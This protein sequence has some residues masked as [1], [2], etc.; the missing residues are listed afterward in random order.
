MRR[1]MTLAVS[2]VFCLA[3]GVAANAAK[4]PA[5]AVVEALHDTLLAV[6]KDAEALGFGGRRDRLA[7]VIAGSFDMALIARVST[8]RHWKKFD[9]AQRA[10]F[11]E[12]IGRLSVAIYAARFDDYSGESFRVVSEQPAPRGTVFVNS[13]L[14]KSDGEAVRLNYLLR[15]TDSDWRIVDVYLEGKYSELAVRRSEYLAVIK[16]KGVDG[17]LAAIEE[18]IAD[19]ESGALK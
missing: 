18:K 4:S 2:V 17:L 10:R 19:F 3:S 14:V 12:A 5:S 1:L 7:P 13:E 16:R 15:S 8:G 6:M 9:D 11:I